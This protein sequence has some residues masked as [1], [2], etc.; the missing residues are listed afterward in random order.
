MVTI[1]NGQRSTDVG[2]NG[3]R[4]FTEEVGLNRMSIK[5]AL[6][7]RDDGP[8]GEIGNQKEGDDLATRLV[9]LL[10]FGVQLPLGRIQN[11]DGLRHALHDGCQCVHQNQKRVEA[12]PELGPDHGEHIVRYSPGQRHDQQ[13]VI[14]VQRACYIEPQLVHLIHSNIFIYSSSIRIQ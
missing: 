14:Q 3:P 11:E 13:H 2:D 9:L 4:P 10:S 7:Q 5:P 12:S 1:E 6:L 8:H